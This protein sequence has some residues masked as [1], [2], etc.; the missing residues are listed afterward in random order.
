MKADY[1]WYMEIESQRYSPMS[2]NRITG[3]GWMSE[4]TRGQVDNEK[5]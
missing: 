3:V 2:G 5:Q 1:F 4:V